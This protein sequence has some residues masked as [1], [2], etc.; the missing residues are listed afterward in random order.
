M[1]LLPCPFCGSNDI[2]SFIEKKPCIKCM[3][4]SVIFISDNMKEK[5]N[6]RSS[7]WISVKD[8]IPERLTCVIGLLKDKTQVVVCQCDWKDV[9]DN[10]HFM[11]QT[12]FQ[13]ICDFE[14]ITHWMPLLQPPK[15]P[16]Q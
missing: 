6:T 8:R 3:N 11:P 5:W 10:W 13:N 2:Y 14:D 12:D 1:E 15:E 16:E 9:C 7:L 4:C